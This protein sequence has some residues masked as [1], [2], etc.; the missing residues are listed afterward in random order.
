[1]K[2]TYSIKGV[3]FQTDVSNDVVEI[4]VATKKNRTTVV[5]KAKKDIK[6]ESAEIKESYTYDPE[7]LIFVNGYQSWTDTKEFT[8]K[9]NLK[10]IYKMPK[11]LVNKFSFDKYGDAPFKKY[12]K[13][14]L[15]GFDYS[16]IRGKKPLFIG[17][18]NSKNAYL[19]INHEIKN[20]Q[21]VLEADC[22]ISLKIGR[23]HV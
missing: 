9:E 19:I 12:R 13:G 20:N 14:V 15:H 10:N 8:V 11:F 5:L 16:Y 1:M 18:Y 23:A 17:T 4:H 7:D 6:I 21:I 2:L 22:K 3:L